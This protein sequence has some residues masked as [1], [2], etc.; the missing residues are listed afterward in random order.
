[1]R[2]G[3]MWETQEQDWTAQDTAVLKGFLAS[4]SGQNFIS[5]LRA[6]SLMHNKRAAETFRPRGTFASGYMGCIVDIDMLSEFTA[7]DSPE[8]VDEDTGDGQPMFSKFGP[9][10]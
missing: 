1:M 8:E 2:E 7:D 3:G 6:M 10:E 5:R 9:I 4:E